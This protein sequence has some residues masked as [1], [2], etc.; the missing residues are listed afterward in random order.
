MHKKNSLQFI[1]GESCFWRLLW[2]SSPLG[3][4]GASYVQRAEP[5]CGGHTAHPLTD[6]CVAGLGGGRQGLPASER[7]CG[8]DHILGGRRLSSNI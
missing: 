4:R 1:E 6:G 8:F 5:G 7:S 3:D 2:F